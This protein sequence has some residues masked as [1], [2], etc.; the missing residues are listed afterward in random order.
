MSENIDQKFGLKSVFPP[1]LGIIALIFLMLFQGGFFASGRIPPQLVVEQ[2]EISQQTLIVEKVDKS[3]FYR[4]VGTVRSRTEV[5]I[6]PRITARI[7]DINVRSGDRVKRGDLIASLDAKDLASVVSQGQSGLRAARAA[8]SSAEEQKKSAR[9]AFELAESEMERTR[10]LFERNAAARSDFERAS[11]SL[12]QAEAALQQAQ[13][14]KLAAT[15]NYA[16]ASQGIEQAQAGLSYASIVSPIDGL[17]AERHADPG[18]MG[19]P[20]SIIVRLFD[21]ESLLLEAPVR[22]SLVTKIKPGSKIKYYVAALNETYEGTIR[23]IVPSV[24]PRTRTFLIKT[25][26][27]QSNLLYPGMFGTIEIPLETTTPVIMIPESAIVRT[28]QLESVIEL[29][30]GKTRRRHVRT[31]EANEGYRK[32]LSGLKAGQEIIKNISFYDN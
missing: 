26:I 28:G 20:G 4:A 17:V 12:R 19:N 25:C 9:A 30:D 15:A 3:D 32:V 5:D 16:A 8:V 2:D 7:L 14:Q 31:I 18:D 23:E 6:M 13:Q 27:E 10:T 21:P 11:T 22:E 29:I 1:L 24:D